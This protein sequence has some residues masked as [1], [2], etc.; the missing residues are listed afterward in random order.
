[1]KMMTVISWC[2]YPIGYLVPMLG[3]SAFKAAV[4]I[5]IGYCVSDIISKVL[6]EFPCTHAYN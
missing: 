1:M 4:G 6:C 3:I 5:Q 2:T